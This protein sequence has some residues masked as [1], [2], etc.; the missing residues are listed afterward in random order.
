MDVV[1]VR[2]HA[3]LGPQ[4]VAGA[5]AGDPAA[6]AAPT[7][8]AWQVSIQINEHPE[9]AA[10]ITDPFLEAEYKD[11]F[12][13]YLRDS[14]RQRWSL[15]SLEL[16]G[17][18]ADDFSRAEDR[19]RAYGEALL[20]QLG[21]F[22][23]RVL[24]A[25]VAEAQL[26]VVERHDSPD[27]GAPDGAG[28]IHCLAWE[29]LESVRAPPAP[30]LRLRVTR[31]SE[32][33]GR[34][35][36]PPGPPRSLSGV[37][38]SLGGV[39]HVL[40]V[41]ARDFSRS[42]TERD[43]EP[44]LAQWPLMSLQ[45]KLRSRLLLEVV[46]PGSIEE[47]DEH[48][49]VR[50]GHG[51]QFNLVHFDLHGRIMHDEHG[52]QVPWLLFAKKHT[53]S[54]SH[55][56]HVPQTRLARA[57]D[58]AR[59]LADYRVENV[60]LNACLSAYNRTGP[61]TNLAHILL[62]RGIHNVSAMWFYVH[63]QTVATYLD[64][65]Y[66]ELLIKGT[67]FHLAAQRGRD[68]IQ[69]NPTSR[70]GR[71]HRDFFLCVNYT[72]DARRRGAA[73]ARREPSPT[74]SARSAASSTSNASMKS[75]VSGVWRPST[76]RLSDGFLAGDE[77]TMRLK[78]HLLELEYK[79]M[80]F[81]VV[82]AS[83]LRRAGSDL[84]ATIDQM[85]GMW[86]GTNLVDDVFY[87]KAKDFAKRRLLT[88]AVPHREKRTRASGGGYL[89]LLFPRP[90]RALRQTLHII[91]DVDP[92]VDPGWQADDLDN[93]RSEERRLLVQE[94][95]QRFAQRLHREGHSYLLFIGSQDAQWWRAYLQHLD[96]EW[97]LHMPWNFTV[98]S[99]YVRDGKP[100]AE[101]RLRTMA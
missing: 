100:P 46:R 93:R 31:A 41:I 13:D 81:R 26:V 71:P 4:E 94:G 99:R 64:A 17:S 96:G 80:T 3:A 85:V 36:L 55:G 98:H 24:R 77:P 101:K 97:W 58:V 59:V 74:P 48:L 19:M 84:G 20:G 67:D 15:Q 79:L 8:R 22:G 54:S 52:N 83:D 88:D 7:R 43:P 44:D 47:L 63:W 92:V 69:Q 21:L 1:Y 82:Y 62:E 40:L 23:P 11:V 29:L 37:Q 50:A 28:G 95:L 38:A 56:Y 65:F 49:R 9:V 53:V 86:L 42:G 60:V 32:F 72:R 68:A 90:V 78:L 75:L 45:K 16:Q 70:T 66:N 89:Q 91:R 30:S 57:A 2:W 73:A 61:A 35:W 87:Y 5:A 25:D 10:T 18:G 34:P 39:F 27:G 76:P 6:T 12:E 33:A 51:V 14:D